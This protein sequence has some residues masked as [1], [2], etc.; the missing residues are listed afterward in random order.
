MLL[1]RS[2]ALAAA[3]TLAA[4]TSAAPVGPG[5]A[6][7]TSQH[8]APAIDSTSNS[9][10]MP[11]AESNMPRALGDDS[12]T[13]ILRRQNYVDL[14]INTTSSKH[15]NKMEESSVPLSKRVKLPTFG[16]NGLHFGR[17]SPPDLGGV[18]IARGQRGESKLLFSKRGDNKLP[19]IGTLFSKIST[20]DLGGVESEPPVSRWGEV[21]N[22]GT[23]MGKLNQAPNLGDTVSTREEAPNVLLFFET[24]DEV[25]IKLRAISVKMSELPTS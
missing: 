1:L 8:I 9:A 22:N 23:H 21:Y 16:K 20:P 3:A 14:P 17:N 6:A 15:F 7:L 11:N 4:L 25:E 5:N 2:L 12:S 19:E 13:I 10:S 24:L 18:V